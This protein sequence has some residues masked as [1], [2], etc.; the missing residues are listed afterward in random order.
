MIKPG[1]APDFRD[2]TTHNAPARTPLYVPTRT[3]TLIRIV[4]RFIDDAP[5]AAAALEEIR[6]NHLYKEKYGTFENLCRDEFGIS[7]REGY[8]LIEAKSV[9]DGLNRDK[10]VAEK[11][12]ESQARA[13]KSAPPEQRVEVLKTVAA[14][15]PVTAKRIAA[16]IE[17]V[18]DVKPEPQR[19]LVT[20][21]PLAKDQ[22]EWRMEVAPRL[23]DAQGVPVQPENLAAHHCPTC[24]C[25]GES[26]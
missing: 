2:R 1:R 24:T 23:Q 19:P 9:T 16:Q 13:L 18:I 15:G 12:N 14:T 4:K 11:I 21:P 5:R 22:T 25:K 8:R 6:D 3:E 26:E 7:A 17:K 20:L 10:F